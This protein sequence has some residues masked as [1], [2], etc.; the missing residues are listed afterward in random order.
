[1]MPLTYLNY[2]FIQTWT[3]RVWVKSGWLGVLELP[4]HPLFN[5]SH[6]H[7]IEL[8]IFSSRNYKTGVKTSAPCPDG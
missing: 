2:L 7:L 4:K 8:E 3:G 1:M 5:F 6:Y